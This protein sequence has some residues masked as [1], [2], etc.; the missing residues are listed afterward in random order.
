MPSVPAVA[1]LG[2]LCAAIRG[3]E[4][5]QRR[6]PFIVNAIGS[7]EVN[8]RIVPPIDSGHHD[9][10]GAKIDTK[11]HRFMVACFGSLWTEPLSLTS[12]ANGGER[13][14]SLSLTPARRDEV[15]L[16]DARNHPI[17]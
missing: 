12:G 17:S 5:D 10:R 4:R 11:L 3:A 9:A 8:E 14:V 6:E 7:F 16:L 15:T 2:V 1:P 13:I